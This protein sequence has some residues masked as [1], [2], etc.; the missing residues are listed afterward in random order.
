[1]GGLLVAPVQRLVVRVVASVGVLFIPH[2][3]QLAPDIFGPLWML[4][5]PS[6]PPSGGEL[7]RGYRGR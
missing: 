2:T 7:Q 1:M 5:S 4:L 3:R 6:V